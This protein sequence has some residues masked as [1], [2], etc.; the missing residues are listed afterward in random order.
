MLAGNYRELLSQGVLYP[1]LLRHGD[2]HHTLVCDLIKAYQGHTMADLWYGDRA[3]GEAWQD[4]QR[5]IVV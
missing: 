3:R 4:L 1:K 2:A 5:E